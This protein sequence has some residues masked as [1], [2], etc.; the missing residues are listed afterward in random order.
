MLDDHDCDYDATGAAQ[1]TTRDGSVVLIRDMADGHLMNAIRLVERRH[2]FSVLALI[3]SPRPQGEH[4][5]YAFDEMCDR[6]DEE[7]PAATCP[8]YDDLLDEAVER[9][10]T[11]YEETQ[12]RQLA[13]SGGR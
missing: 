1:W 11:T 3:L 6:V 7:G 12:Q 4:A 8:V 2:A 10:L 9:G 13:Y 5:G